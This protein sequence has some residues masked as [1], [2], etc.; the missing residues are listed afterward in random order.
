MKKR[1][2]SLVLMLLIFFCFVGCDPG[3]AFYTK[4][5]M[6][7]YLEND[8][9]YIEVLAMQVGERRFIYTTDNI[10]YNKEAHLLFESDK[11]AKLNGLKYEN[12]V[13]KFYKLII[14]NQENQ[15]KE[16]QTLIVGI[17][18]ENGE[19][20]YLDYQL[21]KLNALDWVNNELLL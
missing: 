21:G 12:G 5:Q 20:I 7:T 10:N 9:N 4:D 14:T 18:S 1:I 2:I 11:I 15:W 16:M 13:Q 8:E 19:Q 6:V 17:A 3:W